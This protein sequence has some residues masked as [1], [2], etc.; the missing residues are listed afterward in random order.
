MIIHPL[1]IIWRVVIGSLG[2]YNLHSM[3]LSAVEN[4]LLDDLKMQIMCQSVK[5]DPKL[6]YIIK[7]VS[8]FSPPDFH[9]NG[10]STSTF[11]GS[12]FSGVSSF[13]RRRLTWLLLR[14]K[15]GI[16]GK[17]RSFSWQNPIANWRIYHLFHEHLPFFSWTSTVFSWTS[18][19]FFPWKVS[20]FFE[21][22]CHVSN[23]K[24]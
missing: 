7:D 22:W 14:R 13:V 9:W 12:K 10:S 3:K 21:R 23:L 11:E 4:P 18:T 8:S 17:I 15:L 1:L 2:M 19:V 6:S 16:R 24:E 5:L 20:C